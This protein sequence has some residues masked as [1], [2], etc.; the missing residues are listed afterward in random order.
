MS[1]RAPVLLI[2]EDDPQER[3]RL[4]RMAEEIGF[5]VVQAPDGERALVAAQRAMPDLVVTDYYMPGLDGLALVKRLRADP[6]GARIPIMVI[7][8]DDLRRTKIR[9]LQ[10]G[11]DDFL[12][13]PV[14][15]LE[16]RARLSAMARRAQLVDRL[17]KALAAQGKARKHLEHR[18]A[19]PSDMVIALAAAMERGADQVRIRAHLRR[20]SE[21]SGMLAHAHTGDAALGESARQLSVLHDVGMVGIAERI[22]GH[23]GRLEL[24]DYE[25]VKTHTLLGA[26]MLREA[27]LPELACNIALYHHER[28]DGEGYPHR[29]VGE[30]IPLEARVVSVVDVFDALLTGRARGAFRSLEEAYHAL[31][32]AAEA[33]QLDPDL[34]GS[35]LASSDRV[36]QV[37]RSWPVGPARAEAW[38]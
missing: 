34:T 3:D 11:A 4:T 33:G 13:K 36:A 14:D 19:R 9:L 1:T 6:R 35:F 27:G 25:E 30:N 21:L 31:E 5:R 23:Q 8:S 10:A 38:R 7:T 37:I 20:V 2:A 24:E 22:L 17:G 26:E 15:Q 32:D 29:L 12:V 28:W 18:L 16:Y